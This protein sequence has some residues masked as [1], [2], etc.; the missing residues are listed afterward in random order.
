MNLYEEYEKAIAMKAKVDAGVKQ[1]KE[2][3]IEQHKKDFG[4]KTKGSKTFKDE[5]YKMKITLTEKTETIK[6]V[7]AELEKFFTKKI[8]Y[9]ATLYKGLTD[10]EKKL[11]DQAIVI[12]P[13]TTT[14][15]LERL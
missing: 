2:M 13:S 3:L 1:I 14:F 7:P 6:E 9:S 15:S 10:E 12:K 11:A 5:I 4:K 8:V